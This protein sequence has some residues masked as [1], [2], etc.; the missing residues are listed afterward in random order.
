[1]GKVPTERDYQ[2]YVGDSFKEFND[3][4]KEQEK[5]IKTLEQKVFPCKECCL[6]SCDGCPHK[7]DNH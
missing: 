1:M 4:I 3:T 5:R 7:E 6:S 2:K